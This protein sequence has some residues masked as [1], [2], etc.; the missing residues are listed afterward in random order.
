MNAPNDKPLPF[1]GEV[2]VGNVSIH[3]GSFDSPRPPA[4]SPEGEGER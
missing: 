3:R 2:G 1:R 4:P